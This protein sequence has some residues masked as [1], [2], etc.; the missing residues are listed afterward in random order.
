MRGAKL[1]LLHIHDVD[2]DKFTL[3]VRI[4]ETFPLH[5]FLH[6]ISVIINIPI[7]LYFLK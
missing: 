1:P 3:L 4:K 5:K 6:Q 7:L 2:R